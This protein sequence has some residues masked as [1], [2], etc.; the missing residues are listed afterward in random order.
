MCIQCY[1]HLAYDGFLAGSTDTFSH[2]LDSKSVEVGLQAAQHVVQFV[3]R[4][5]RTG[6][7]SLSLGLDLMETEHKSGFTIAFR[8]MTSG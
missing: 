3:G 2:C 1:H 4:F 5:G 6:R 7:G 8:C